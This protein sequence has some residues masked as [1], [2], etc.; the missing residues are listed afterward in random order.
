MNRPDL[1]K[2]EEKMLR[3]SYAMMMEPLWASIKVIFGPELF[4]WL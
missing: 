1:A 2:E 3:Q 4:F